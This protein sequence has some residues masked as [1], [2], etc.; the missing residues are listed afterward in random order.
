MFARWL[1]ASWGVGRYGESVPLLP[2]QAEQLAKK[3]PASID[4]LQAIDSG[5]PMKSCPTLVG[6]LTQLS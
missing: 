6:R 1:A 4:G 2:R 5:I 3:N